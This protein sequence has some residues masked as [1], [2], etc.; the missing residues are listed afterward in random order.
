M[1]TATTAQ[2]AHEPHRG[3]KRSHQ[4]I[5]V[6][7]SMGDDACPQT[8]RPAGRLLRCV[9]RHPEAVLPKR[10]SS[11]A[12]GYDLCAVEACV[13]PAHGLCKVPTGLA[14]DVGEGCYGR[15][16]PRS[17]LAAKFIDVGAGVIDADYR[18]EVAVILYNHG[19]ADYQVSA[20]DHVAQIII[21]RIALPEPVWVDDL[22]S[23]ARGAGGFGSTGR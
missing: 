18:G 13:V 16:A 7:D 2:D 22:E 1:S 17:S 10:G 5:S 19:P 3:A 11:G 8:L 9:K 12:A 6:A 14:I 23:T 15:V 20:R 4:D 21:E